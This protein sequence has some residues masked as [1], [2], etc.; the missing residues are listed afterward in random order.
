M[1]FDAVKPH[2]IHMDGKR[3]TTY[4]QDGI[5]YD[6]VTSLQLEGEL[7]KLAEKYVIPTDAEERL[8]GPVSKIMSSKEK[9]EGALK[10]MVDSGA[11]S[12]DD[13]ARLRRMAAAEEV[14]EG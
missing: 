9:W 11:L 2:S 8:L 1:G 12:A 10:T 14:A 7:S 3:I 5:L 6:S 13:A 4:D